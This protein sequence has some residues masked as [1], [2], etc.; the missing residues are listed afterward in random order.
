MTVKN[1]GGRPGDTVIQVYASSHGAKYDRP[2]RLLKGFC[3]VGLAPG[4]TK[5]V[6]VP[7]D[8]NDLMF[9]SE[10]Q[11]TFVR[12]PVYSFTVTE[13]GK[14]FLPAGTAS[15]CAGRDLRSPDR[16]NA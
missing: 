8:A 13:N 16:K 12:D 6:A 9:Y 3:R 14:D 1:T 10:E 15:L 5:D 11:K 4:E 7:I 2:V